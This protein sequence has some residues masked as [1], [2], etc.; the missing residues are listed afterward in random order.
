VNVTGD[1]VARLIIAKSECEFNEDVFND[2]QAGKAA[3][4]FEE[5]VLNAKK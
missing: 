3:K 5:Q 4:S 1:E 2:S